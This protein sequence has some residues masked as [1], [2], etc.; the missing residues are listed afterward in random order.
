VLLLRRS[1]AK[2]HAPGEWETGSGGI[3]SGEA[4]GV[5]RRAASL[6]SAAARARLS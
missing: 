4:P 3:L 2:D 6:V 1:R 5:L